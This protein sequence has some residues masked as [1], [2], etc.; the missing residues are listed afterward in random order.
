MAR[1]PGIFLAIAT[2][3]FTTAEGK[4]PKPPRDATVQTIHG[5]SVAD[6]FLPL[7][8]LEAA[9]PWIDAQNAATDAFM[10]A[11]PQA[12]VAERIDALFKIG[13]L[14]SPDFAGPYTFYL[15]RDDKQQQSVL[16]VRE[17]DAVRALVDPNVL[18][19]EGGVALDWYFPSRDGSLLAYGTSLGGDEISTL[20]VLKVAT[21]EHLK[22][23]IPFTRGCSLAWLP[24]ASGFVYT[25]FPGREAYDRHVYQHTLGADWHTDALLMGK[26]RLPERSDWPGVSLSKDGRWLSVVRYVS[27][28]KSSLH[29]LD[30]TT[31]TWIDVAP[32]ADGIF[33]STQVVGGQVFTTSTHGAPRGRVVRIDPAHPT[34]AV[35]H[36]L[37]PEGP[38]VLQGLTVVPGGLITQRL[39]DAYS[40]LQ[41]HD[42]E[43]AHQGTIELPVKGTVRSVVGDPDDARLL[44]EFDSFFY[45]PTLL[46]GQVKGVPKLTQ[47]AQVATD[48]DAAGYA[49]TQVEYPSYDG[50]AVPMFI[51]HRRDLKRDASHP[52][53]LYG[54]G[55]FD[56][57]LTPSFS[58]NVLFWLE[59]GGVY[60]VA[61]LRGGG[62][63]GETWHAAGKLGL[64]HQVFADF[65]YAMRYLLRERYTRPDKLALMGGSNGGL[66]MG[67]AITQVPH[68]F[69]AAVAKVGLYDMLRYDQYPPGELWVDEYGSAKDAAQIGYLWAYSPYHQVLDGVRYPAVLASAGENDT[70]V[71][72]K[73]TA[74]FI[75]RL[76]EANASDKPLLMRFE[77]AAGHGA[78]KARGQAAQEYIETYL[79]L[80]SQIGPGSTP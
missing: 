35:W 55:G 26:D 77:R 57:S 7:E 46:Q 1:I 74:K 76:Q 44:V 4:M 39:R 21:G 67:A 73:H 49:V 20:R 13:V 29:L 59:R 27:W 65:E 41:L 31:N 56:V 37:V 47:L 12:G 48:F 58:R 60:A 32:K 78:G 79:F 68:L 61:N 19:A 54:Y 2:L 16:Y 40:A 33:G 30:R 34:A 80:L 75:A 8:D 5:L 6:P 71:S 14:S 17:G 45:P 52:T 38:D 63:K 10:A 23:E 28:S 25:R 72:W 70:R 42:R 50:T 9:S 15:A 69:A 53:L 36:V 64:K 24:D 22:D 43:G 18:D 51:I 11:H 66:L 3:P 62:E